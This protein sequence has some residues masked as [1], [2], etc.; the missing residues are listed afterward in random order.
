MANTEHKTI[1]VPESLYQRSKA[2]CDEHDR[3]FAYLVRVALTA[4]L[5]SLKA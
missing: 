2:W 5:D 1:R 3:S 4:F